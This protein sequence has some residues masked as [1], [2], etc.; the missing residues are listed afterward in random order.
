MRMPG[1][2]RKFRCKPMKAGSGISDWRDLKGAGV[3][4][5][6]NSADVGQVVGDNGR[7]RDASRMEFNFGPEGLRF[8]AASEIA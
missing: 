7:L 6:G 3:A 8:K 5:V 2:C 1:C 4:M